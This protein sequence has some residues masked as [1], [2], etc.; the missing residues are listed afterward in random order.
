MKN[1]SRFLSIIFLVLLSGFI[2]LQIEDVFQAAT[3]SDNQDNFQVVLDAKVDSD[4]VF[5][6]YYLPVGATNFSDDHSVK[7]EVSGLSQRQLLTFDLPVDS[8]GGLRIDM[9]QEP[10]QRGIVLQE[11]VLKKGDRATIIPLA[12]LSDYFELNQHIEQE[13]GKLKLVQVS[14]MYDPFITLKNES[15]A[16]ASL[17]K[18]RM[19]NQYLISISAFIIILSVLLVWSTRRKSYFGLSSFLNLACF[20][21][22]YFV[23][24]LVFTHF[25]VNGVYNSDKVSVL[26]RAKV[27]NPDFFQ[28]FYTTHDE[29]EFKEGNSIRQFVDVTEEIQ[30]ITFDL[31]A[32]LNIRQLRLDISEDIK[33]QEVQIESIHVTHNGKTLEVMTPTSLKH[34]Y[35]NEYMTVEMTG[36]VA[37]FKPRFVNDVYDPFLYSGDITQHYQPVRTAVQIYPI[38]ETMAMLISL[39]VFI[40][41][42]L[43]FPL[44]A[45]P[46]QQFLPV[47][48]SVS[49]ILLLSAPYL[50]NVFWRGSVYQ[51]HENR[52][53]APMPSIDGNNLTGYPQAFAAYFN[54]NFGF[55]HELIEMGRDIRLNLFKESFMPEKVAIGKDGWLFLSGEYDNIIDDYA[56]RNLYDSTKLRQVA[57]RTLEKKAFVEAKGGRFFK[58]FYPNSH[59]IYPELLPYQIQIQKV[60]TLSRVE[61]VNQYLQKLDGS[62]QVIDVRPDMLEAKKEAQL[63]LKYDTHWN[64]YGAFIGYRKLFTEMASEMPALKPRSLNDYDIEWKLE[65]DG[66][67]LHILGVRNFDSY[68]EHKPHFTLKKGGQLKPLAEVDGPYDKSVIHVNPN[69]T[70]GL[71]ALVFHDSFTIAMR[72]FI[73]GHFEKVIYY[74]G[75]YNQQV[76]DQEKPDV[77]IESNVERYFH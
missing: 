47:A 74:W 72:Q 57:M 24:L 71:V 70:T 12:S 54:D 40:F 28:L 35:A 29:V 3:E 75:N 58:V 67:L 62:I 2:A 39:S 53:L 41:L 52:V 61:Q 45:I 38:A 76:I 73:S 46:R 5:Q 21:G 25:N 15:M 64:N 37:S 22:S 65:G 17:Y 6:V 11:I 49:F 23:L 7:L 31:P 63:Y 48:M 56:R 55:R 68:Q 13:A 60:D 50:K 8:I 44:A 51:N 77:V 59:S 30:L 1:P 19:P 14:D 69:D 32:V 10:E 18:E 20:C 27:K 9:G 42:Q 34:M 33:Q 36:A 4:D 66:D 43:S 16:L 26:V